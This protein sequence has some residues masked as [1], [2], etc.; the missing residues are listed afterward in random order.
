MKI[1]YSKDEILKTILPH[2]KDK[3]I[4][5]VGCIQHNLKRKNKERIWVHD[6]LRENAKNVKG[7]DI[8]KKDIQKLKN[9]GYDIYYKNAE[10]FKFNKNFDVI[11]AGE[12]IEHLSNPGLFLKQCRKHLRENGLL[13]LTTP[14]AFSMNRLLGGLLLFT[15]DVKVNP[16]HTVWFSPKVIKEL[17]G[18][19][20]FKVIKIDFVNFPAFKFKLGTRIT[21]FLCMLLG[22]RFRETMIILAK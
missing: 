9:Q 15:N 17:L 5:D 11:F 7:I 16:E 14:N 3:E 20:K 21:N 1:D 22:G 13:I 6:F 19:Y 12:L 4:L 8:I 2:I 10:N 18:R